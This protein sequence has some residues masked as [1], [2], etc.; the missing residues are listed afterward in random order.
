MNNPENSR[1]P[2]RRERLW[3]LAHSHPGIERVGRLRWP[4]AGI[5][6]FSLLGMMAAFATAPADN[7]NN[8]AQQTIVE[9][10]D[11][12]APQLVGVSADNEY[13]REER[14]Q[15]GDTL[16]S[17]LIRLGVNDAEAFNFIRNDPRTQQIARQLRPGKA[18]SVRTGEGGD[19][20]TLYFPLNGKDA[21]LVVER[22]N[23]RLEASEQAMT[24]EARTV[25]KSGEIRYSLFGATDT[26]GIPD[27]V[28]T[29]LAEVFG[30]DIDFLRDLRKGDR[31]SVV[32]EMLQHRGQFVRSGRILA[33]EFVNNQKTFTAYWHTT[34]DGHGGYYSRNGESL[35]KAFLR[36]PLEFSR[37]TSGFTSARFHPVLQTWR[38]HKGV[39]YGAPIGTSVRTVADG[40]VEF[41]GQQSGYGNLLVIRHSGAYSSAYGHLKGFAAG[42]RKGTSVQQGETV[43]YV[44]QT[45]LAT[46]P[47]LHY[48]FRING[49]QVNPL[50]VNLPPATPLDPKQLASFRNSLPAQDELMQLARQVSVTT[51]E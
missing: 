40:V 31:F 7:A 42:I 29:Q 11:A 45:G 47:H 2:S 49:Q 22:R 21:S 20:H 8:V 28:A 48:E 43:A 10:L 6:A 50:A 19:L 24:L 4:L 30:A 14:V 36:S 41:A 23:G 26:A 35:R 18:V 46:G 5:G 37:V 15:R 12:L 27:A 9:T 17:L 38:A 34:S 39:D 33:A 13:L 16:S 51:S 44:G 3:I 1:E 25:F 32:Y